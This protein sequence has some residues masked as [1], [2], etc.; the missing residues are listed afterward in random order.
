MKNFLC[1]LVCI[2]YISPSLAASSLV[3]HISPDLNNHTCMFLGG[4]DI[5]K[6]SLC[7]K[8]IRESLHLN[9]LKKQSPD[10][11]FFRGQWRFIQ[12]IPPQEFIQDIL[13]TSSNIMLEKSSNEE[14]FLALNQLIQKFHPLLQSHSSSAMESLLDFYFYLANWDQFQWEIEEVIIEELSIP[15]SDHLPSEL[16]DHNIRRQAHKILKDDAWDDVWIQAN[17][18]LRKHQNRMVWDKIWEFSWDHV[19]KN[20]VK[21][22]EFSLRTN[23]HQFDIDTTHVIANPHESLKLPIY[24]SFVVFHLI[25]LVQKNKSDFITLKSKLLKRL[26]FEPEISE[27][28]KTLQFPNQASNPTQKSVLNLLR[29]SIQFK[30]N[31]LD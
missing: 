25:S 9:Y 11:I 16:I 7:S 22:L 8:S 15:N 28:F 10:G 31:H 26:V 12:E 5:T 24:Y 19:S 23:M 18:L 14:K 27:K 17:T 6:L 2:I 3:D 20:I 4:K 30:Q 1:F 21:H 13:L 29:N